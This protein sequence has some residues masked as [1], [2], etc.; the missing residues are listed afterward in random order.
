MLSLPNDL[1]ALPNPWYVHQVGFDDE[2][3][4]VMVALDFERGASFVCGA[5]G[6]PGC[7]AYDTCQKRW[8]HRDFFQYRCLLVAY[9][10][11]ITC[12]KCGVR[13]AVI[14]WA[15]RHARVTYAFEEWVVALASKLSY[16][17]VSRIVGE[18]DT[19]VGRIVKSAAPECPTN[20]PFP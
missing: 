12:P 3:D 19:R 10:P 7:K 11:R 9:S 18:H 6:T 16:R 17:A 13:Q 5:C 8:R 20:T 1:L 14:P 2:T 4:T 15:R